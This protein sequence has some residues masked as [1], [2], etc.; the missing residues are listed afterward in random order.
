MVKKSGDFTA[1]SLRCGEGKTRETGETGDTGD[2][3]SSH[4]SAIFRFKFATFGN[5]FGR[6]IDDMVRVNDPGYRRNAFI[7]VDRHRSAVAPDWV[8]RALLLRLV[9]LFAAIGILPRKNSSRAKAV[10]EQKAGKF[11]KSDGFFYSS[12]R[13]VK[14]A[15][16]NPASSERLSTEVV[17]A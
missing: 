14:S 15:V 6:T 5:A 4:S 3:P 12:A 7:R 9:R 8:A 10:V 16:K 11:G 2:T 17:L 13:S 1:E